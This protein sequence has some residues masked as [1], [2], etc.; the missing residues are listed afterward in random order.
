MGPPLEQVAALPYRIEEDGRT[1][2]LLVTSRETRRWVTPKG[3]HMIG[4]KPHQAAEIEA[5]EEAG[6]S[7][8]MCSK[9]LGSFA[10]EKRL[11]DGSLR[12]VD[13]IVFLLAVSEE[14]AKW[15]ERRQRVRQWFS[16]DAA[17]A[18]VDESGLKAIIAGCCADHRVLGHA[19]AVAG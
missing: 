15:P 14:A 9:P 11:G 4:F 19:E 8:Q 18:A 7:G 17:A 2:V 13:C 1:S 10:Y 12:N 5:F 6:I 3:N 16:L